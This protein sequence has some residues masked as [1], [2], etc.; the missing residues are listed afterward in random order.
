MIGNTGKE[1]IAVQSGT[2]Q[3]TVT[4]G[5]KFDSVDQLLRLFRRGNVRNHEARGTV[6]QVAIEAGFFQGGWTQHAVDVGQVKMGQQGLNLAVGHG[7]MFQIKPDTVKA[8]LGRVVNIG[9][10]EM[11]QGT[12][13]D[14]FLGSQTS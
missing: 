11:P 9:R 5:R 2:V 7:T 14:G 12:H 13:A 4:D 1:K 6:F 10:D 3:A 8:K